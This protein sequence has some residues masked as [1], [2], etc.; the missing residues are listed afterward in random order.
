MRDWLFLRNTCSGSRNSYVHGRIADMPSC[1]HK[2]PTSRW[3]NSSA[4][5]LARRQQSQL[6]KLI[7]VKVWWLLDKSNDVN[8][9]FK[10]KWTESGLQQCVLSPVIFKWKRRVW[11][12]FL[13][14]IQSFA[15]L[16][17]CPKATRKVWRIC[18]VELFYVLKQVFERFAR[19]LNSHRHTD[20]ATCDI[21]RNSRIYAMHAMRT[22]SNET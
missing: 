19:M 18:M 10:P 11:G 17:K 3:N 14:F 6:F 20:H 22:K 12:F 5:Q 16:R 2:K 13:N 8:C 9:L 4:D 7:T 15:M 21:C 1:R